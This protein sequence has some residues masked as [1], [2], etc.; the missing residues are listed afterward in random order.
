MVTLVAALLVGLGDLWA[1]RHLRANLIDAAGYEA[2]KLLGHISREMVIDGCWLPPRDLGRVIGFHTQLRTREKALMVFGPQG[3]PVFPPDPDRELV[4]KFAELLGKNRAGLRGLGQDHLYAAVVPVSRPAGFMGS[5]VGILAL[6]DLDRQVAMVG[7]AVLLL[8]LA[9]WLL[10]SA[11]LY[12]SLDWLVVRRIQRLGQASA[13]LAG[14][15]RQA[16]AEV[17]GRDEISDLAGTFNRMA[18]SL[19][20]AIEGAEQEKQRLQVVIDSQNDGL[21]VVDPQRRITMVNQRLCRMLG[22][23]PERIL[24]RPCQDLVRSELCRLGCPLFH[25]PGGE[26]GPGASRE[27]ESTLVLPGGGSL[28]IRKNAKLIR[29]SAGEITGGVETVRDVSFEKELARLRAEWESFMRHELRTPLQPLLGFSRLLAQDPEALDPDKRRQYLELMHQSAEHLGRLL[30]MTREVQLYEAGRI[31]LDLMPYDLTA[32]LEQAAAEA[33]AALHPV[34]PAVDPGPPDWS[35]DMEPGLDTVIRQDPV[36]LGRVFRNL[37][38]NAWEH[39]PGTVRVGLA[40]SGAGFVSVA[41]RNQGEPIPPERLETIFEKFNTT[42][43]GHGGT[44]LGTT[45]ARLFT[46]A[47]GGAITVTSSQERGT[48]FMVHLPRGGPET[49]QS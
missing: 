15:R 3:Q 27:L 17:R 24:G 10:L 37:L 14:G 29:N 19:T 40:G 21:F 13:A 5:L 7:D 9:T 44:G 49:E 12:G 45:I 31:A 1:Y 28:P 46:A 2:G 47:H 41:V 34:G 38:A 43:S 20:Q 16:R 23:E 48:C 30:E 26:P 4:A 18:D 32:T 35:L 6:G 11:A 42:K 36:K 25:A 33:W 39:H 22:L 8:G